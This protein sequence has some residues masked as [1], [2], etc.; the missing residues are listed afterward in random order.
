VVR[1]LG[2]RSRD[3]VV[4]DGIVAAGNG[5]VVQAVEFSAVSAPA[6]R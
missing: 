6:G 5:S 3:L 2:Q 4:S 1:S